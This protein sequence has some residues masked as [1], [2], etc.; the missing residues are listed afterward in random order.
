MRMLQK[1]RAGRQGSQHQDTHGIEHR[2]RMTGQHIPPPHFWDNLSRILLIKSALRELDRRNDETQ[3]WRDG[4]EDSR[5]SP[6]DPQR[7]RVDIISQDI[8]RFSRN[9]GPDLSGFRDVRSFMYSSQLTLPIP[10]AIFNTPTTTPAS[11]T[12]FLFPFPFSS[13]KSICT[14]I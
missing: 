9:G 11:M 12:R 2:N 14:S 6:G 5:Q 4:L 13:H 7:L 3:L 10:T 1:Q 8:H